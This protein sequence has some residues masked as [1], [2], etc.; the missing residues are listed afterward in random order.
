MIFNYGFYYVLCFI[1]APDALSLIWMYSELY[2]QI[3]IKKT[4]TQIYI[5]MIW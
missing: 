5:W 4:I 2:F 3:L 1:K